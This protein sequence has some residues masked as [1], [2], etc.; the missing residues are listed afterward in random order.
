M[1]I[2][3]EHDQQIY[4][5]LLNR[6]KYEEL[7][8]NRVKVKDSLTKPHPLTVSSRETLKKAS[9]DSRSV[10]I[11]QGKTCLNINVTSSSV[12]RALLIFDTLIK[13]REKRRVSR[14][15]TVSG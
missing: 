12:N 5:H 10:L 2:M 7:N 1:N 13:E 14:L 9:A 11:H 3:T 4:Q 6:I 8:E 15:L